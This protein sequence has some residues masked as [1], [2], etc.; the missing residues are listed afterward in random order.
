MITVIGSNYYPTPRAYMFEQPSGLSL[1]GRAVEAAG[2]ITNLQL[3][4]S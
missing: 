3:V 4:C 1:N 2:L